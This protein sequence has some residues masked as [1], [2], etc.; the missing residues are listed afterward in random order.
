MSALNDNTFLVQYLTPYTFSINCDTSIDDFKIYEHGGVFCKIKTPAIMTFESLEI[1]IT[2]PSIILSDLSKLE[3]PLQ[4]LLAFQSLYKYIL[5]KKSLSNLSKDFDL[6]HRI[7]VNIDK[8]GT[9][10]EI[11]KLFSKTGNVVFAPLCAIIGGIISQ[12]V[13]KSLTGKFTPLFQFFV[14]DAMELAD[15]NDR[16]EHPYDRYFSLN[17]CLSSDLVGKLSHL[18]LFMVGCGAI[19]CELLKNFALVGLSTKGDSILT[20]TDNDLIEK[21][22]LNRQFLFRPWHIQVGVFL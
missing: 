14:L 6:L 8:E 4:V 16:I 11:L 21:S 18:S 15:S 3:S 7:A 19:G 12:E 13:L 5:Q 17:I 22:N 2:K 20:I 9:N 10:V 1:Q